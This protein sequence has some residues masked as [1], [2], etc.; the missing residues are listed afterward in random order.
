MG[1][2]NTGRVIVGGLLAGLVFNIGE[3]IL[4]VFVVAKAWDEWG[5]KHQFNMTMGAGGYIMMFVIMFLLGIFAVWLYAA[6]R[7]RYS[8][9]PRTALCAGLA[10][11]LAASLY[12]ALGML[13]MSMY[14]FSLAII[15]LIWGLVEILLGTY[16]GAWY[17][18]EQ[19]AAAPAA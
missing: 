2:I 5:M 1:K 16:L 10:V 11:W 7:P 12:P 6:I 18:R 15:T 13:T 8:A 19:Q 9:G 3:I 4:N 17:Y 14:P